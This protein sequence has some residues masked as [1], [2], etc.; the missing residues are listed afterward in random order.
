MN[1]E[2][3]ILTQE[4]YDRIQKCVSADFSTEAGLLNM[5]VGEKYELR[6]IHF[7]ESTCKARGM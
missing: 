4:L 2:L 6:W 7:A 5:K 1:K 3:V